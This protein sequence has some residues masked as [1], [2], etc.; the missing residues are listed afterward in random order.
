MN[1]TLLL[2]LVTAAAVL[3]APAEA[4]GSK[5][6]YRPAATPD[7]DG[8]GK[9]DLFSIDASGVWH[10]HLS[11]SGKLRK[12]K[13]EGWHSDLRLMLGDYD[14]DG[15]TD[16]AAIDMR[17]GMLYV[18]GSSSGAPLVPWGT[19]WEGWSAGLEP[20]PGDYDGDGR[21][22]LAVVRVRT[23]QWYI[24]SSH[25][26]GTGVPHIPWGCNWD[27]WNHEM[28]P[29]PGDYDGDGKVD[30]A[31]VR[32]TTGQWYVLS[33]RTGKPGVP[34]IPWGCHWDG[35]TQ[36][37]VPIPGDYD[38]DGKFDRAGVRWSTGECYVLSSRTGKTG[39]PG[40]PWG[41]PWARW[42]G[43]KLVA[44][45]DFTGD[46]CVNR[47]TVSSDE[48]VLIESASGAQVE[49]AMLPPLAVGILMRLA[50]PAFDFWAI[51]RF[52]RRIPGDAAPH[53]DR[54]REFPDIND[55]QDRDG[56][57]TQPLPFPDGWDSRPTEY[58]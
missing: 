40:I 38:G 4:D 31:G 3:V 39:V 46:G 51:Y 9:S 55:H 27:G 17:N 7:F 13:W 5:S 29:L 52:T 34:H 35:W 28:V 2:V 16:R 19:V 56:R 45:A 58:V 26:G 37:M 44:L 41:D 33:S 50:K 12:W 24:L 36:E 54:E 21:C 8:D 25:T 42:T 32:V 43:S 47:L 20:V 57:P 6:Q 15:K 30:R 10:E 18:I 1:S 14:G 49:V 53:H 48:K 11:K 22:D 23:G